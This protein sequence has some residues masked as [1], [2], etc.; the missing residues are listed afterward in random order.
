MDRI[1]GTTEM[2]MA[3]SEWGSDIGYLAKEFEDE[4]E[5]KKDEMRSKEIKAKEEAVGTKK[6]FLARLFGKRLTPR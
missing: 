4:A 3:A 6:H 5:R 2:R 1:K